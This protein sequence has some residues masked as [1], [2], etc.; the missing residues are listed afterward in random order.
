MTDRT[1]LV[2]AAG[3]AEGARAAAAALAC[4]AADADRAALL[5][6]LDGRAPRAGLLASASA[7]RLEERLAA[8][9]PR[10]R[11]ASRGLICH[12]AAPIDDG[13]E[14]LVG[15]LALARGPASVVHLPAGA[16]RE[17]LEGTLGAEA[18]GVLL[19]ADL[20]ADRALVARA[21]GDLRARGLAVGVLK[22]PLGWVVSQ[23]ALFGSLP[24]DAA[25]GLPPALLRR[26][27]VLAPDGPAGVEEVMRM[28]AG[29]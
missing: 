6:D 2:A 4:A 1:L 26:L 27:G 16:Y 18:T 25:G 29:G 23:R 15:A 11:V 3:E 9:L 14:A 24:S 21:V 8:H 13:G 17:A 5:V 10:A 22:R 12:L 20:R 7:R 19:R 28:A